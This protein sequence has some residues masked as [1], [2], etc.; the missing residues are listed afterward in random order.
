MAFFNSFTLIF[1]AFIALT[2]ASLGW[3]EVLPAIFPGFQ[4]QSDDAQLASVR[5]MDRVDRSPDG[6][7]AQLSP[8][9]HLRRADIYMNNRAFDEA[10]AHWQALIERYPSDPN[11]AAALYGIGRSYFQVRRY[12]ESLPL[13]E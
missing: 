2:P 3:R 4:T 13:L 9:E 12:E 11:V 1:F 10:R 5:S 6:R 8:A 7:L